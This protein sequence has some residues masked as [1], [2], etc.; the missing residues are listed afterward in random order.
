M[1]GKYKCCMHCFEDICHEA[2][3]VAHVWPQ[4]C[5]YAVKNGGLVGFKLKNYFSYELYTLE[6]L[7]FIVSHET[8]KELVVRLEGHLIDAEDEHAFCIDL[9]CHVYQL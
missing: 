3:D 5:G 7:G 1:W 6:K 2:I 8:D 9:N 4:L